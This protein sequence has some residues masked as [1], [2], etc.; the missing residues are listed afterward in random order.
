MAQA[1]SQYRWLEGQGAAFGGPGLEPRWTSSAKDAVGT[2]YSASSRVW[3]TVSHGILNEIYYPTIDRPQIRDMQFLIT[4]GETF[5]HEERRNLKHEFEYID[6]DALG[7]R[8]RNVDPDGRYVLTKEI[9]SDP[10]YPVVLIRV[11]LEGKEDVISRLRVY[12]LLSPHIEGGGMGNSARVVDVAGRRVG[13]A[14]RNHTS[15]AMAASC[16]FSRVSCGYV[17][18]SDGWQ[19]LKQNFL[20]D[21]EFGSALDGNVSIMGEIPLEHTHRFVIAIGFGEGHHA[22]LA[23]TLGAR[24]TKFERH[25]TRFIEQWHRAATPGELGEHASD[26]GRLLQISHNVVLAHED[27]TY[28]G[29]FIASAS[30]PW[31]YAKGDDDLGGYH[32]VW[33]RDMVQSATALMACGRPQT[34]LRAL[35]YLACTQKPD[36]G[37]AQNFWID[38]TPY[39]SGIQLDEVAF[40]IMLAWRLWKADALGTFDV[41]PFVERAAGFLVRYAPVTQQERWEEA[42]GYSPSTLAAVISGLVCAADMARAHGSPELGQ[43]LEEHADWIESHLEDWT[44]TNNGVLDPEVKRH[45]MRI[46]P[47]ECGDPYAHEECGTETL[48]LN[49]RGPGEKYEFEAREVID[50]GFLELVRYGVR[51][52]DDPLIVDSLKV[53]DRV[54]KINAPQGPCWRRYNHDGYGQRHDGGPYLGWGQGRAWPLLTGERAHYELAAG[55]DVRP[56]IHTYEQFASAGGML[57]EQ[58]WDEADKN[59]LC[60]GG[61]AGSAMPLVWAHAEYLKLLRSAKDGRVYDCIPVVARRYAGGEHQP[62]RI[63]VYKVSRRQIR[64]ITAGKALRMTSASR[65]RV[66]WS[67]DGWKTSHVLDSTQVGFAGSYADL[68]TGEK[69]TGALS[70]TLFW[71]DEQRWE[72]RNFDV[73]IEP[74]S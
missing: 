31:G 23:T 41:F 45:Y 15:L 2:A 34:A 13:L 66:V 8:I 19:D 6:S 26:G 64:R 17:G 43:F 42:A 74:A 1:A 63:E 49:N 65:F 38:G 53:V 27:K 70:F 5:F 67:D 39:W 25:L 60:F 68:P 28:G 10:H 22:A 57:P 33:T 48:R 40:P 9:I 3:F 20:M 24:A 16:G 59:G 4:D 37:F 72:G 51:R 58:I 35:V 55:R 12:A 11:K 62:S 71:S 21:W 47:P 46:R 7:V 14:W 52:P 54:L 18:A 73:E 69:Q 56:L 29:A 50:A 44:V 30:I 36:G 32:L 61:P